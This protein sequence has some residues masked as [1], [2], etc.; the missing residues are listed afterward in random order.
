[1]ADSGMGQAEYKLSPECLTMPESR[2]V[3]N[4]PTHV[5]AHIRRHTHNNEG[6][7]KRYRS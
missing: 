3:L 5:N 4:T 6:M 7:S 1:M 2:K